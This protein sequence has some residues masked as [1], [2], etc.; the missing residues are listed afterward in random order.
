AL[1]AEIAQPVDAQHE[2][3]VVLIG[4]FGFT[5]Q[6]GDNQLVHG[7]CSMTGATNFFGVFPH[8]HRLGQHIKGWAHTAAGDN[9]VWNDDYMFTEQRFGSFTPIPLAMGDQIQVDCIYINDTGAPVPFGDS[10]TE[11]MCFA[12]SYRYP[13][14][15]PGFGASAAFCSF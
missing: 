5:V 9:V 6:P 3:E 4:P 8:M 2:A 15:A 1:D 11:E 14:L 7:Q 13:K 10:T 12:I